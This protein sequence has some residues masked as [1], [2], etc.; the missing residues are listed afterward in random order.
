MTDFDDVGCV[1]ELDQRVK[2]A[3]A[4]HERLTGCVTDELAGR[5]QRG[6][7]VVYVFRCKR[8]GR[9][10]GMSWPAAWPMA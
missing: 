3:I 8:C 10:V 6:R 7:T 5:R 9:D 4:R 1:P 2:D